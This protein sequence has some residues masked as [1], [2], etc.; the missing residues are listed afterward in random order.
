[1]SHKLKTP[2][3]SII[4]YGPLLLSEKSLTGSQRRAIESIDRQGNILSSLVDKLLYFTLLEGEKLTLNKRPSRYIDVLNRSID[5]ARQSID[6]SSVKISVGEGVGKM[7]ST[8]F[9]VEKVEA[10]LRNLIEN[11]IKFNKNADKFVIISPVEENGMSGLSVCD[12][13]PG[14]PPEE[15][16]KIFQKFYQVEESFTG[17]VEGAGLGLAIVKQVVEAHGGTV[18]LKSEIGKGSEFYFLIPK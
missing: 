18:G 11:A 17:Q 8:R 2:L 13:G 10:V 1:M 12:N 4:G 7:P 5:L 16:E 14:V 6:Q 9:D 15:R 3:V